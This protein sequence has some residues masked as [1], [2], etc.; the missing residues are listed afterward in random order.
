LKTL[1]KETRTSF[2]EIAKILSQNSRAQF[3][4]IAEQ[5]NISTKTVINRY[6]RLRGHVLTLSTI[7]VDLKKLGYNAI[8]T[9]FMKA[10]NKSKILEMLK[11]FKY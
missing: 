5:L 7:T 10:V 11:C 3:K 1:L 9:L 2:T 6:K 8:A 4:K